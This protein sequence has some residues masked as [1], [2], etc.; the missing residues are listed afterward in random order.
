MADELVLTS[1]PR[2]NPLSLLRQFL[3][4]LSF[5]SLV[6]S[7]LQRDDLFPH[8]CNTS[9]SLC[10]CLYPLQLGSRLGMSKTNFFF[11]S[12]EFSIFFLSPNSSITSLLDLSKLNAFSYHSSNVSQTSFG[13]IS[14]K[15]STIPTVSKPA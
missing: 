9:L 12:P 8:S 1:C 11:T 6:W 15:Y 4:P 10:V 13:H 2:K 14:T 3:L 7:T 5:L